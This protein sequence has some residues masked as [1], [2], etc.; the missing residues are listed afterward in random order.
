MY[1][2]LS[3]LHLSKVSC[4]SMNQALPR[5]LLTLLNPRFTHYTHIHWFGALRAQSLE[6]FSAD[7]DRNWDPAF[8]VLDDPLGLLHKLVR[9]SDITIC[10]DRYCAPDCTSRRQVQAF[11]VSLVPSISISCA[12]YQHYLRACRGKW[13]NGNACYRGIQCWY[14]VEI[15]VMPLNRLDTLRPMIF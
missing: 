2:T 5:L 6:S 9:A 15:G 14:P 7:P 13:S 10:L 12:F 3:E 1:S 11:E 4:W 8:A